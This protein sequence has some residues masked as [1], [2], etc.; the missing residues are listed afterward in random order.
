MLKARS[1]VSTWERSPIF[2]VRIQVPRMWKNVQVHQRAEQAQEGVWTRKEKQVFLLSTQ[3]A[4]KRKFKVAYDD[5][6]QLQHIQQ[7][8][9]SANVEEVSQINLT[10][11]DIKGNV[12]RKRNYMFAQIVVIKLTDQIV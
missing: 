3:N 6:A 12:E 5:E 11:T 9:N 7:R 10:S 2:F 4:S 1:K 8:K